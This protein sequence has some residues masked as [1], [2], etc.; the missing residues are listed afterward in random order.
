M[1]MPSKKLAHIPVYAVGFHSSPRNHSQRSDVYKSLRSLSRRAVED[2]FPYLYVAG[3]TLRDVCA[4][5]T[6]FVADVVSSSRRSLD[7]INNTPKREKPRP[8]PTSHY[9]LMPPR[10]RFDVG[11]D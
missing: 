2:E 1:K 5:C 6:K 4:E 11:N 9:S 3:C 8:R 10:G 7:I